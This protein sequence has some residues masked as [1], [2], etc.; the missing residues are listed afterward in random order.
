MSAQD[1]R[2]VGIKEEVIAPS[3]SF[4][5]VPTGATRTATFTVPPLDSTQLISTPAMTGVADQAALSV[6]PTNEYLCSGALDISPPDSFDFR[7]EFSDFLSPIMNQ[8][9]CGSCWAVASTQSLASR[10]AFATNQKVRPLSA[11]YMLFCTRTSFSVDAAPTYGCTGGSLAEAFWFCTADGVVAEECLNY[12]LELWEAGSE[13]VRRRQLSGAQ[14]SDP[15][16][17]SCPLSS[18][19][20]DSDKEPWVYRTA[21]SYIVAGTASQNGGSE[22]NIRRDVWYKGPVATG[23]EVRADFI[24]YWKG[25]LEG[26]RTDTEKIYSPQPA[27]PLTNPTIGNHAVQLVGWGERWGIK[28]WIVANSWGA[29]NA[30]I[31][32]DALEDYGHNG[33][34]LMVRGENA[35][36]IESNVVTGVPKVHPR[37]VGVTGRGAFSSDNMCDLI[38]FEISKQTL[39]ALRIEPPAPLP[40]TQNLYGWTLPPLRT[41]EVGR[42]RRFRQCPQDRPFPCV[43]SGECAQSAR[44]CG[45]KLPSQ[46]VIESVSAIDPAKAAAREVVRAWKVQQLT[47]AKRR[48]EKGGRVIE[49]DGRRTLEQL[50]RGANMSGG[51]K[52]SSA[53][54]EEGAGTNTSTNTNVSVGVIVGLSAMG[55]V[56]FALVAILIY[57]G[58]VDA[59]RRTPNANPESFAWT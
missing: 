51:G 37:A 4:S 5:Y 36:A 59:K 23:Y 55:A 18:C 16:H 27:H 29:T 22:A 58:V 13:K 24:E 2:P 31:S 21:V 26:T 1:L 49:G 44:E 34:F 40:D 17:V 8:G 52:N 35:A 3:V 57:L 42:I 50:L 33:Y 12:D 6:I 10:F 48:E 11:A 9:N 25:L 20:S 28:Y 47:D 32:R 45:G 38:A 56:I 15:L 53:S 54:A 14:G 19:P 41:E 30:G 43:L 7:E 46:G 39:A